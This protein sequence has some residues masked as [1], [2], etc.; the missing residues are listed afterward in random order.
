RLSSISVTDKCDDRPRRPSPAIT[1]KCAGTAHLLKVTAQAPHPLAD[2]PPVG[3]N[4]GFART[5]KEAKAT[6]LAFQVGPTAYRTALLINEVTQFN[7]K[8][9]CRSGSSFTKNFQD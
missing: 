7:V 8:A 6:A 1:V 3:L 2:H 9:A 5:A 4:L